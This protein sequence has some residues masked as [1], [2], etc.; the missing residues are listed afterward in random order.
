MDHAATGL[1]IHEG[2]LYT[3]SR[4]RVLRSINPATGA[5]LSGIRITIDG[6]SIRRA[7]ALATNPDTGRLFAVTSIPRGSRRLITIDPATGNATLI[8]HFPERFAGLAFVSGASDTTPPVIHSVDADPSEIWPPNH[9]MV[10][11]NVD[12]DATDDSGDVPS[13][14]ITAISDDESN[15]PADNEITGDLDADVRAERDGDGD[16]R[17][18]T[19]DVTGSD[20]A[21]NTA[22]GSVDVTVAHDQD[23]GKAKGRN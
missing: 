8:G 9:K 13:C 18:Y 21:G 5:A 23:N 3:T 10:S 20:A 2:V 17:T 1:A 16:G 11:V 7:T 15:D 14:V 22:D 19:I 6:V 4:D 12:V